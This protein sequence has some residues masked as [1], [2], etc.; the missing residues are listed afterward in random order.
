MSIIHDRLI[1][2][3]Q[4]HNESPAGRVKKLNLVLFEAALKNVCR[5][6]R[7][8]S[9]PRGNLLL[10]GVG[11]SGKQSLARLAAFVNNHDYATLTISK[12]FGVNQLFDAIREQY[13]NAATKRAV[14]MLFTDNDIKQ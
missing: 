6:S 2:A 7:G 12:G 1:A 11:G 9:L 14:T 8:L 5:I 3:M 4:A 13:I 10:V